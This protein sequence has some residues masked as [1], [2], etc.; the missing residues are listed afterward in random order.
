MK[1]VLCYLLMF[2]AVVTTMPHQLT[3]VAATESTTEDVAVTNKPIEVDIVDEKN[4]LSCA[5]LRSKK[6]K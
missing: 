3:A 6:I 2:G 5:H 4:K 1:Y